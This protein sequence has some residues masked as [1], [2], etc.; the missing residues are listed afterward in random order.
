MQNLT[1]Q[2]RAQFIQGLNAATVRREGVDVT[3][4]GGALL[5]A[6]IHENDHELL[7]ALRDDE[8]GSEKRPVVFV[9]A[10]TAW[11]VIGEGMRLSVGGDVTLP[12][13][14]GGTKTVSMARGYV[15]AAPLHPKWL[16]DTVTELAVVGTPD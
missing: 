5:K 13:A 16:T 11:G 15:V 2:N 7:R 4:P 3:L 1:V 8:Q 9:F 12:A 10:G 6:I 14:G